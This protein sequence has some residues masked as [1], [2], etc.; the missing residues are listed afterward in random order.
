[1]H[2]L[3][4]LPSGV[5]KQEIDTV[6]PA[7]RTHKSRAQLLRRALVTGGA[8]TAAGALGSLPRPASSSPSRAQDARIL[9]LV[10]LLEYVEAAFYADARAKGALHGE[11][12]KFAT[13]VGG[14]EQQHIS[15][16]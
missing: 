6:D 7:R 15:F 16:L 1:M 9:N 2:M 13:V 14:H 10:L 8:L 4:H 3:D 12:Q 11:L 5:A